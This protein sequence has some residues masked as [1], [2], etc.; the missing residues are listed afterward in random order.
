MN[1]ISLFEPPFDVDKDLLSKNLI[2]L[3]HDVKCNGEFY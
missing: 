1:K 3:R 2:V